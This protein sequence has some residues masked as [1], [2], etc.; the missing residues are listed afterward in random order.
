[1]SVKVLDT[2]TTG[3]ENPQVVELAW[4]EMPE[5]LN[6][7]HAVNH[8]AAPYFN[9]RFKPSVPIEYGAAA[10][11]HIL[12]DDLKDCAPADDVPSH[13]QDHGIEYAIGHNIDFDA[14]VL[15]GLPGA[16]RICTLALARFLLPQLD[17][18]K[19]GAV[20]YY[21]AIRD[22]WAEQARLMQKDA[23]SALADVRMCVIILTALYAEAGRRGHLV[24]SWE[25]LYQLSN[26]ARI[27]TVMGFGKYRGMPVNQVDRGYVSWYR[28]QADTDPYYLEAFRRA[29]Y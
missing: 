6:M 15:G 21:F 13:W 1:M 5:S 29:G 10:T 26:L 7:L 22:G 23:H 24:E 12:L 25:D 9:R 11:H 18:H 20:L 3:F 14:D 19:Q 28:K 2:E 27:P 16:K 17:S 8:N 4:V